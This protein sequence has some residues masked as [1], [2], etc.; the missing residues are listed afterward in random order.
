[1]IRRIALA[2]WAAATMPTL[3]SDAAEPRSADQFARLIAPLVDPAK[4]ATL[5]QRAAN[6]RLCKA[7][8]WLEMARR[9]G[10]SPAMVADQA[11]AAVRMKGEGAALTRD[12]LL[13]NL[14]IAERL[15]CLDEAGMADLRKGQSPTIR[16]GPYAGQELTVDHVIPRAVCPELDNVIANLE[17]LPARLNSAKGA[18]IG[19]RQLDV[20]RKLHR[21]GLLSATGLKVVQ[22]ARGG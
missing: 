17:F 5:G 14:T 4:L 2:V 10:S 8:H 21:A 15:G 11:L 20:A 18:R 19:D 13:R 9:A 3:L 7:V 22:A 16:R 6:P 12:A 1:M